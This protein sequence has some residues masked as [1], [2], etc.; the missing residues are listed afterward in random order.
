[1]PS[2]VEAAVAA[3]IRAVT[4]RDSARRAALIEACF[5]ADGRMVTRSREIRGR[6][7]LEQEITKFQADPQVLAVRVT[8]AI[9][10]QGTTFR[11]DSLIERRDGSVLEFF[12][13]GEIDASGR[14]SLL[15]AFAGP[16]RGTDE[17]PG[18][19]KL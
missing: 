11:Y 10:A 1:M 14:I 6:A 17:T 4:E 13:A 18:A 8:S 16:L 7:A 5:A 3:Y 12:D 2:P 9:H 15:L 19:P